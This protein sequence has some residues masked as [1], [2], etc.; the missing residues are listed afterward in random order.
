MSF[1]TSRVTLHTPTDLLAA[2]PYLLGFHPADSVVVVGL[3][4]TRVVFTARADLPTSQAPPDE[5]LALADQLGE[6]LAG[7]RVDIALIIGYGEAATV[8]RTVFALR[9]ALRGYGVAVGEMLR[10][11]GARYWS[12]LCQSVRCCPAEGTPYDVAGTEV[13]AAATYAGRVALPDRAALER[14]LTPTEGAEREAMERATERAARALT[15]E[16]GEEAEQAGRGAPGDPAGGG[17]DDPG[18]GGEDDPGDRDGPVRDRRRAGA[19]ALTLAVRRY[20]DGGRLTDDEVA[21]LALLL[22]RIDVRDLCWARITVAGDQLEAH[23]RLWRDVTRRARADLVAAPATL[24]G[25]TAWR[26][27]DGALA[28]IAVQRALDSNPAYSL[29][30]LLG[31]ALDRALPPS[32]LDEQPADQRRRRRRRGRPTRTG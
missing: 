12:Y 8:T 19:R 4:G 6:V 18:D 16:L 27:G 3:A 15:S 13:A 21:R 14:S 9:D 23:L 22:V 29:A 2:V 25:Y 26:S 17:E 20:A 5:A 28:W 11:D 30:L 24:F 1:P 7:Q 10:A 31:E 32:L